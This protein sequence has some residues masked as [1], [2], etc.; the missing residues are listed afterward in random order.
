MTT[1]YPEIMDATAYGD[2]ST[3]G[4]IILWTNPG[5]QGYTRLELIKWGNVVSSDEKCLPGRVSP[6]H[7]KWSV[8][9]PEQT[10]AYVDVR[11]YR[12]IGDP[13]QDCIAF[14]PTCTE[15]VAMS[16]ISSIPVRDYDATRPSIPSNLTLI[17]GDGQLEVRW[18]QVTNVEIFAYFLSLYQGETEVVNGYF[19]SNVRD[20]II[21]N[22]FNGAE[23]TVNVSALSHSDIPGDAMS[24]TGTPTAVPCTP[25]W[26]CEQPVNGY[27]YDGCG[28]RRPNTECTSGKVR[29]PTTLIL[30]TAAVALG[31]V[32]VSSR[33]KGRM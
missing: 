7:Y 5:G 17:P 8:D 4:A 18:D 23:Y 29:A 12:C 13:Q 1:S 24:V 2:G 3:L 26:R 19:L 6:L 27:E 11:A 21:S 22:L 15:K 28:N 14:P 20:V 33:R 32:I 25:N 31:T 9:I 16:E 30:G 10:P